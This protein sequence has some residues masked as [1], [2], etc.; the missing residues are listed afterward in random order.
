MHAALDQV[1]ATNGSSILTTI[2]RF[3]LPDAGY[4]VGWVV[5]SKANGLLFASNTASSHKSTLLTLGYAALLPGAVVVG[6][7]MLAPASDEE[8]A[9]PGF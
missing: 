1:V 4:P 7:S 5:E 3:F 2:A 8:P 9:E 6:A